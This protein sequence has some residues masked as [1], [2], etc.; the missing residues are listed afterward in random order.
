MKVNALGSSSRSVEAVNA[1]YDAARPLV[2]G[3]GV[4][5]AAFGHMVF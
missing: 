1:L 3:A 2:A 4:L 5:W